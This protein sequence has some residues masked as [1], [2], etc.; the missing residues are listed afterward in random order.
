M[1]AVLSKGSGSSPAPVPTRAFPWVMSLLARA[2]RLLP[3]NLSFPHPH[4]LPLHFVPFLPPSLSV[5]CLCPAAISES[6]CRAEKQQRRIPRVEI[7][8]RSHF[9]CPRPHTL[10][11]AAIGLRGTLPSTS[12]A[13]RARSPAPEPPALESTPPKL[14]LLCLCMHTALAL[15]PF[16]C[17]LPTVSIHPFTHSPLQPSQPVHSSSA[18]Q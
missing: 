5:R 9:C 1:V 10:A 12:L 3:P 14:P 7:L 15:P 8:P 6:H 2:P 4:L 11:A 13:I 18:R 17:H 16:L